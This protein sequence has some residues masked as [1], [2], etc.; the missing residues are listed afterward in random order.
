MTS[1]SRVISLPVV[2]T[3]SCEAHGQ[4]HPETLLAEDCLRMLVSLMKHSIPPLG[5]LKGQ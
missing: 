1:W 3:Q 5:L 4:I 2:M